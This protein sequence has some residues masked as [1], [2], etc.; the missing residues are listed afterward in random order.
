MQVNIEKTV[1]LH[2]RAQDQVSPTSSS[3]AKSICKYRCPHLNCG[4]QFL[5]QHGMKVHAG[6]CEWKDEFEVEAIVGHRGPT[7]A[8]QYKIRWKGYHGKATVPNTTLSKGEATSTPSSSPTT[9]RRK[10]CMCTTGGSVV[11]SATFPTPQRGAFS[12]TSLRRIRRTRC[13]T[14]R[15]RWL[16]KRWKSV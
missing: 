15:V 10:V 1:A 7:V 2:V 6:R 12:S 13:K 3:Q 16:M 4:F 9:K 14:S 11:M 5:T 8:R